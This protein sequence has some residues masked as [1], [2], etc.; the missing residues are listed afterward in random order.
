MDNK[1]TGK[2]MLLHKRQTRIR[3]WKDKMQKQ[4]GQDRKWR[5]QVEANAGSESC[6]QGT[7][8]LTFITQILRS[9]HGMVGVGGGRQSPQQLYR[10]P[11]AGGYTYFRLKCQLQFYYNIFKID[12]SATLSLFFFLFSTFSSCSFLSKKLATIWIHLYAVSLQ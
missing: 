4:T 7:W 10:L 8:P 6:C 5:G 11:L 3:Y 9:E 12:T 1:F 2:K